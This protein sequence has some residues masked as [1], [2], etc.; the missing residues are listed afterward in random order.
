MTFDDAVDYFTEHVQFYPNARAAAATDP[1]ARAIVDG[2]QRAIYRYSKWPTQAVTYN[3]GKQAI[4]EL[5][6]ADR[7]RRGAS[8]SAKQ[9]HERFMRMGT[10]PVGYFRESFLAE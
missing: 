5:R 6:D 1:T 4:L 3:L 9:F 2:A 10:I 7:V 8:W